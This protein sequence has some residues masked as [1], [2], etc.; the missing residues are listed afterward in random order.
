RTRS[1]RRTAP[2]RDRAMQASRGIP[3]RSPSPVR[4]PLR[5]TLPEHRDRSDDLILADQQGEG[6]RLD[7]ASHAIAADDPE[8]EVRSASL[9]ER[10]PE[11]EILERDRSP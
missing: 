6:G 9:A 4:R 3:R 10:D 11:R 1:A 8:R 5:W 2:S 7:R